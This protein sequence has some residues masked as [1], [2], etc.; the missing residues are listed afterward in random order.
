MSPRCTR[1][2]HGHAGRSGVAGAV[3][4][5]YLS[6]LA[7]SSMFDIALSMEVV[8]AALLGGQGHGVGP[9][10]GAASI[11]PLSESPTPRSAARTPA[12]SGC[13]VRRAATPVA[14]AAAPRHR[15]DRHRLVSRLLPATGPL[16]RTAR[17][18]DMT[19]P[20]APAGGSPC[21]SPSESA[22]TVYGS[23]NVSA[24]SPR[25]MGRPERPGGLGSS[26]DR[27]ERF[28]QT[29]LFNIVDGTY[30]PDAAMSTL[31]GRLAR[32]ST[33]RERAFAGIAAPT[34][35]PVCSTA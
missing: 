10:A 6:F 32:V 29:T 15:A 18:D 3:Y 1:A 33:A 11:V 5:Y 4:G 35:C 2:V 9:R 16:R 34:S 21:H 8:L 14:P 17:P 30:L 31:G 19:L 28:G 26:P 13:S 24:G 20:A 12:R 27:P 7:A 23:P 22:A 25:S